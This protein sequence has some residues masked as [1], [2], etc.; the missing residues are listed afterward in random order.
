[1]TN[2]AAALPLCTVV[3]QEVVADSWTVPLAVPPYGAFNINRG[4]K[5]LSCART[6]PGRHS[7]WSRGDQETETSNGRAANAVVRAPATSSPIRIVRRRNKRC[8]GLGMI[9][10]ADTAVPV[11]FC[12]T[13]S[14]RTFR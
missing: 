9:I 14:E 4:V 8:F 2:N 11:A 1:M 5:S 3:D 12:S 13:L 6:V 7:K 10:G